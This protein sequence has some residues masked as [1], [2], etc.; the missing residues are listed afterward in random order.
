MKNI[1]SIGALASSTYNSL[2]VKEQVELTQAPIFGDW[3][4][5]KMI[6]VSKLVIPEYQRKHLKLNQ[7]VKAIGAVGGIDKE[8]FGALNVTDRGD[9]TY[10]VGNGQ[11][12]LLLQLMKLIASNP[13]ANLDTFMVP[14]LVSK[15]KPETEEARK[16]WLFNGGANASARLTNEEQFYA[17]VCAKMPEALVLKDLLIRAKLA[18][19]EVGKEYT[20]RQIAYV[21]LVKAT[22]MGAKN[23]TIKKNHTDLSDENV[24]RVADLFNDVWPERM[25]NQVFNGFTYLLNHWHYQ[26]IFLKDTIWARFEKYVK[27]LGRVYVTPTAFVKTLKAFKNTPD[28][29]MGIAFGILSGF[30]QASNRA[31]KIDVLSDEVADVLKAPEQKQD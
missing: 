20:D 7:M 24:I 30:A 3:S 17:Q 22:Q 18:C 13:D 27:D 15:P 6:P 8:F 29:S 25:D 9:D 10:G 21:T 1:T 28:W 5:H 16:F 14:C 23:Q 2:S 26:D 4:V 19:G 11:R 31:V 12:R